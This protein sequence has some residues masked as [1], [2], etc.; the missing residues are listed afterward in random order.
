MGFCYVGHNFPVCS[1]LIASSGGAHGN[2]S[3]QRW[4]D[5]R[6][7]TSISRAR[8][9]TDVI[10]SNAGVCSDVACADLVCSDRGSSLRRT[11]GVVG[12]D[13]MWWS[14]VSQVRS[15]LI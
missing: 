4:S 11:S 7:A 13:R 5:L 2:D 15:A 12:S 10:R 6:C 8:V 3:G 14:V 9:C 1:N